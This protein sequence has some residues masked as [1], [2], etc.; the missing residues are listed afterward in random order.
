MVHWCHAIFV[1]IC[2]SDFG[3]TIGVCSVF[4]FRYHERLVYPRLFHGIHAL[5]SEIL[6]IQVS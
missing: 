4:L 1:P 2:R 5:F 3:I 6:V